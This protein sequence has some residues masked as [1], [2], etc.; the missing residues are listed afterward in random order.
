MTTLYVTD[1]SPD[2]EGLPMQFQKLVTVRDDGDYEM[3]G[4]LLH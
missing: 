2:L 4:K 1:V 3:D